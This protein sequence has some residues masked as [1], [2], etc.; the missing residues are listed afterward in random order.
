MNPFEK[1]YKDRFEEAKSTDGIDSGAIWE[2]I[3]NALPEEDNNKGGFKRNFFGRNQYLLLLFLF[4]VGIGG[5]FFMTKENL[6]TAQINDKAIAEK[7]LI[8]EIEESEK[9]EVVTPATNSIGEEND[10]NVKEKTKADLK[11]LNFSNE[12]I[13]KKGTVADYNN[14]LAEKATV[15]K[16][17]KEGQNNTLLKTKVEN[18]T[19]NR[20]AEKTLETEKIESTNKVDLERQ[21]NTIVITTAVQEEREEFTIEERSESNIVSKNIEIER[22]G[23]NN[24]ITKEVL[25]GF[26]L[27]VVY[28]D[29]PFASL[30]DISQVDKKPTLPVK[31]Y[32]RNRKMK[33]GLYAG[34]LG[35]SNLYQNSIEANTKEKL[36]EAT[37]LDLGQSIAVSLRWNLTKKI[38]LSTGF[39]YLN[40][41]TEFNHVEEW[42]TL[43]VVPNYESLGLIDAVATRTV[44]HNNQQKILSVPIMIGISKDVSAFELGV[45]LGI[46]LNYIVHQ[47]GKSLNAEG[48]IKDYN[49]VDNNITPYRQF[50]LSYQLRPYL[51]CAVTERLAVELQPTFRY[52]QHGESNLYGA[53]ISS[54]ALG[55]R[56]GAVV[57]F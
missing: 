44:K 8:E 7:A 35:W 29:F 38:H 4:L 5:V 22:K 36:E 20:K 19:E 1:E 28:G 17:I 50:F 55:L 23:E 37:N 3:S 40:A 16:L 33:V 12:R 9:K 21:E 30:K 49:S 52:Q 10:L 15:T 53:K 6:P 2:N 34:L 27:P 43:A 41:R 32:G 47:K 31:P 45:E 24:T 56:L 18:Q 13:N 48:S 26:Q 39:E 57:G 11:K 14:T 51:N 54:Y 25:S 46:G 42:D